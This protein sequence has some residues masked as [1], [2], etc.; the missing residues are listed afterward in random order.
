MR[1]DDYE[2]IDAMTLSQVG[3]TGVLISVDVDDESVGK[4]AQTFALAAEGDVETLNEFCTAIATEAVFKAIRDTPAFDPD[5]E[6][7]VRVYSEHEVQ[8][9]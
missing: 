3:H 5:V 1:V 6:T 2:H 4:E 7:T 9:P 8:I